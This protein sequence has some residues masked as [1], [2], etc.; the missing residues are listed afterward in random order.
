MVDH[1]KVD[2][3]I[4]ETLYSMFDQDDTRPLGVDRE[5]MIEEMSAFVSGIEVE[6]TKDMFIAFGTKS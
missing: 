5:E 6:R 1:V 4:V 2:S 3:F